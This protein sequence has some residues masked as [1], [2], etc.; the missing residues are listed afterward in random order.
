MEC[1]STNDLRHL[2]LTLSVTTG[3]IRFETG[4]ETPNLAD[5]ASAGR[6]KSLTVN[7]RLVTSFQKQNAG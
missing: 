2:G 7:S 3:R 6:V 5:Q 4:C 1:E